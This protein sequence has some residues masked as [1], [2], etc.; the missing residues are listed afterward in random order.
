MRLPGWGI[1]VGQASKQQP[2]AGADWQTCRNRLSARGKGR[3]RGKW[4]SDIRSCTVPHHKQRTVWQLG[5]RLIVSRTAQVQKPWP[6]CESMPGGAPRYVLRKRPPREYVS[7]PADTRRCPA[8]Q[9]QCIKTKRGQGNTRPTKTHRDGPSVLINPMSSTMRRDDM[10][11]LSGPNQVGSKP[12]RKARAHRAPRH[13]GIPTN[14]N[15][16]CK[17][18]PASATGVKATFRED[19][20]VPGG[21]E[22]GIEAVC[23]RLVAMAYNTNEPRR[24]WRASSPSPRRRLTRISYCAKSARPSHKDTME[25]GHADKARLGQ[26]MSTHYDTTPCAG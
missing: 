23:L 14:P 2:N 7:K 10:P 15:A 3:L 20:Y 18:Q 26:H 4:K 12:R 24:I 17:Q 25:F 9:S 19:N 1:K 8:M 5:A 22:E 13:R 21:P 6:T 11:R 16:V